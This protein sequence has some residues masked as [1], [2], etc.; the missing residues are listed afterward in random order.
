MESIDA[1]RARAALKRSAATRA[2]LR[3]SDATDRDDRL[4]AARA[5]L[6]EAM[7]PI[8][9]ARR[10]GPQT[11]RRVRDPKLAELSQ[12]LQAE[13]G[14]VRAMLRKAPGGRT[15][16]EPAPKMSLASFKGRV[17]YAESRSRELERAW[18]RVKAEA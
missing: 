17:R 16:R 11:G 18:K 1:A 7:R 4:R 8:A 13:A 14:K 3:R 2:A 10:S 5:E 15:G 12:A 9:A 6:A